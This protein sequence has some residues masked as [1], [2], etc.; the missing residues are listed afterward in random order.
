MSLL[1][2][3]GIALQERWRVAL[4]DYA[5]CL[6]VDGERAIVGTGDGHVV[7]IALVT[8]A[9]LS[10]LPSHRHGVIAIASSRGLVASAGQDGCVRLGTREI[11]AKVPTEEGL[12]FSSDGSRLAIADG[13]RVLVVDREGETRETFEV[14]TST[15]AS[16]AYSPVGTALA[17]AAYGGVRIFGDATR[18][19]AW[20][21]SFLHVRWSPNG[22]VIASGMQDGAVHFWRL[23][24][25]SDSEMHGFPGKPRAI[26]WDARSTSLATAGGELTCVWDFVKGPEGERPI[27]LSGQGAPCERLVFHPSKGRLAGGTRDGEVLMWTPTRGVRPEAVAKVGGEV[28]ALVWI[29]GGSALLACDARGDVVRFDVRE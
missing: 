9:A 20:K 27:V 18:D 2:K 29:D 1:K 6:T 8:G 10:A 19:L 16:L 26:A 12:S 23:H 5:T 4:G 3:K 17:A 21:G 25:G 28:T 7:P 24:D 15:I 13:R 14:L 11:A 22:R